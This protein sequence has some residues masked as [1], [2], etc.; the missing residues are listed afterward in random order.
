MLINKYHYN[1]ITFIA[2]FIALV[3]KKK[4]NSVWDVSKDFTR[5]EIFLAMPPVIIN[6]NK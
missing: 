4:D 2:L 5:S 1:T 3:P 6:L